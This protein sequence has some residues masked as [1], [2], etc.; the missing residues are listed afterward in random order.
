MFQNYTTNF[1]YIVC[2]YKFWDKAEANKYRSMNVAIL[3]CIII[4]ITFISLVKTTSP[5]R[6]TILIS[7]SES[8]TKEL[9]ATTG[10]ILNFL[11][12]LYINSRKHKKA[13]DS[14]VIYV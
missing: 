9:I 14:W 8:E 4:N 12:F 1:I 7:I 5:R 2:I 13:F 11:M 3:N 10:S 6:L